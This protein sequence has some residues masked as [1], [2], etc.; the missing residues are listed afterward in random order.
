[1]VY[2]AHFHIGTYNLAMTCVQILIKATC[3]SYG[4][5]TSG[6]GMNPT[7]FPPGP[8]TWGSRIH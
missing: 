7:V 3:F 6:K 8:V 5:N 1:M 2:R 4:A